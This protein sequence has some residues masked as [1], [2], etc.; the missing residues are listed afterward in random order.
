MPRKGPAYPIDSGWQRRV[1]ERLDDLNITQNELAR[2]A[3]VSKASLSEALTEGAVQSTLVPVIHKAL[4]W[5][6][7]PGVLNPDALELLALYDQM[8]ERDQGAMVERARAVIE[9]KRRGH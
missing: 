7:P 4:G 6:V 5:P 9:T 2:R 3:R 1:L 8:S